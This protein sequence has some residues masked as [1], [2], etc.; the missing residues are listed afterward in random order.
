MSRPATAEARAHVPFM[1]A[2]VDLAE[3]FRVMAHGDRD[4]AIGDAVSLRF[5]RFIDRVVPYFDKG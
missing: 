5:E 4:L 2:L 1:I 3:G